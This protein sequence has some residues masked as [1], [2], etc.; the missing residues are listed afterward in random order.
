MRGGGRHLLHTRS[1]DLAAAELRMTLRRLT[2]WSRQ[3]T[4]GGQNTG[5]AG[6]NS[7]Y[8]DVLVQLAS[9]ASPGASNLSSPDDLMMAVA[10]AGNASA[11]FEEF[12]LVPSFPSEEYL[13]LLSQL[14]SQGG[15]KLL[16]AQ[17]ILSPY[18][19]SLQTRFSA[20]EE[21]EAVVRKLVSLLNDFLEEKTVGFNPASG[22]MIFTPSGEPL[23]PT[24]LSSGE[25]QL[26]MLFCTAVLARRNSRLF[27][28]DEPELSLGGVKW[29]RKLID[30]LLSLT[31]GTPMQ[32]I[33]ATH[34]IEIS[35]GN[36]EALVGL[37]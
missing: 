32:L 14:R 12:D 5:S 13:L 31:E 20:L 35:S 7:I 36:P 9:N 16:L 28:I 8:R 23:D 18:L 15:E 27:I 2:D 1:S 33:V 26:V 30:A 22:L 10:E 34:S 37:K 4:L 19:A 29:Q 6:A 11:R 3:L 25:R 21:L 17:Q 24:S